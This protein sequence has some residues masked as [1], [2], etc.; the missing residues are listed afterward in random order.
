[1]GVEH[2]FSP[3]GFSQTAAACGKLQGAVS[4]PPDVAV[5]SSATVED[6]PDVRYAGQQETYLNVHGGAALLENFAQS[7]QRAEDHACAPLK[8]KSAARG[9][10]KKNL[11]RWRNPV[12]NR[13]KRPI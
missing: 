8:R 3:A 13:R 2:G 4:L 7:G 10:M 6:L 12:G 1:V 11:V 9:A 5:H